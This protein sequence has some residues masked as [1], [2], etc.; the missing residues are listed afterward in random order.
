MAYAKGIKGGFIAFGK[1]A[2]PRGGPIGMEDFGA[3]REYFMP[4]RLVA[5]VPN[6]NVLWAMQ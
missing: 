5:N 2:W 4:V 6:Q 1:S 3:I